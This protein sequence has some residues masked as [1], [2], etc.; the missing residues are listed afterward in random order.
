MRVVTKSTEFSFEN[1]HR[2]PRLFLRAVPYHSSRQQHLFI[3]RYNLHS[4][5]VHQVHY[6]VELNMNLTNALSELS[7]PLLVRSSFGA[8]KE[9]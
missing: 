9:E 4:Y 2:L 8:M 5:T 6:N 3:M 7:P 1:H